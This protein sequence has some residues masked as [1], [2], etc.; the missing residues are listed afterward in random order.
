LSQVKERGRLVV[1]SSPH[2][3][4]TFMREAAPGEFVGFDYEVMKTFAS[5]LAVALEVRKV[6]SFD[7]LIPA[8]LRGEGDLIASSFSITEE[9]AKRVDF[10]D[11]YFPVVVMVVV[12]RD[13]PI[14]GQADLAG[15]TGATVAGSSLE[16]R[17][18]ALPGLSIHHVPQSNLYYETVT[19]GE[20]DFA[21]IDSTSVLTTLDRYPS[22]KVAFSFDDVDN[23]GFAVAPGSDLKEALNKHLDQMRRGGV[24]LSIVRRIFGEKGVEL[25]QMA[26]PAS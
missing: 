13:S 1:L 18:L 21:F 24:F 26:R 7:E 12:R 15:R 16:E 2:S 9:R 10:S 22:L 8:L 14:K 17:M 4:S 25:F 5:A 23:Y 3:A 19:R 6:A 20:A 11:P